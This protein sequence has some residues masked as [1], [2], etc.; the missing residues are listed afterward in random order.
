LLP[1][2]FVFHS[3]TLSEKKWTDIFSIRF[4][5]RWIPFAIVG[6]FALGL[7][8]IVSSS[9]GFGEEGA[10]AIDLWGRHLITNGVRYLKWMFQAVFPFYESNLQTHGIIVF[11]SILTFL[12]GVIIALIA[13]RRDKTFLKMMFLLVWLVVGLLPAYFLP[14]HTYMYYATFSLPAFAAL[15]FYAI[16]QLLIY[17]KASQR[18]GW[19]V[20]V[21][22]G[23]LAVGGSFIQSSRI[24]SEELNQ[25][26]FADGTNMLFRRAATQTLLSERLQKDFPTLPSGLVIVLVNADLGS[27]GQDNSALQYLFDGDAFELLPPSAVSYENGNWFFTT[28]DSAPRYLDPSLVVV[29]ELTEDDI[30]RLELDDLNAVPVA[31]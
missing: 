12:A 11:L 30:L 8:F 18:V 28:P 10:Y 31:P 19:T 3:L 25:A 29:Y 9:I 17:F 21:L 6:G 1:V 22:F 4:V 5:S 7:K 24:F 26:T 16:Q 20:F 14:N 2:L 23:C 13:I 27:F 15:F